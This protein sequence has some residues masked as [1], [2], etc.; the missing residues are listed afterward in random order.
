MSLS[1]RSTN[2]RRRPQDTST[3]GESK[4]PAETGTQVQEGTTIPEESV[5]EDIQSILVTGKTGTGKKFI[6]ASDFENKGMTSISERDTDT[7]PRVEAMTKSESESSYRSLQRFVR[8][9]SLASALLL[10]VFGLLYLQGA[11]PVSV[12]IALGTILLIA[13]AAFGHTWYDLRE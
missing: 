9:A 4:I 1:E 7:S 11:V 10:I 12:T 5:S 3:G 8:N 6:R 2:S 13:T